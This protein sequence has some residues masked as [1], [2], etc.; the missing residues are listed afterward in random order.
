M[1]F[2]ANSRSRNQIVDA[3]VAEPA[4]FDAARA[5]F[6]FRV[7]LL[8]AFLPVHGLGNQVVKRE[9]LF[10]PAQFA[11]SRDFLWSGFCHEQSISPESP[12]NETRLYCR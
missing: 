4:D 3:R 6:G 7:P 12:W 2:S 10:S 5:Q 11:A 9:R 8:K 1:N